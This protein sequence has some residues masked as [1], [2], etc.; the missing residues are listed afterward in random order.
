MATI[1]LRRALRAPYGARDVRAGSGSRRA[2]TVTPWLAVL[3]ALVCVVA[4]VI[5]ASGSPS[6]VAFGR[7]LLEF[8]VVAT[9]IA[10]GIYALRSPVDARFGAA[11]L[12]IGFLWS[13]TALTQTSLSVPYTIGRISTWLVL[14]CV[15]YLLLAF[16]DGRIAKGLDRVVLVGF[17]GVLTFLFVGTA[18]LVE[19]FPQKTLWSSCTTACPANAVF[20]LD[21]QPA[22]LADLITIREWLVV[23]LWTG[24][25]ASMYRRWR[26]GSPFQQRAMAPV[27][28]AGAVWGLS[29]IGHILYRQLGGATDTVIAVSSVW[30]AGI[31]AV[32]ATFVIGLIRRRMLLAA[33]LAKLGAMLRAG[34]SPQRVRDAL[35]TAIGDPSIELLF[36][37]P[38]SGTWRDASGH[39]VAWP[40]PPPPGRAVTAIGTD[41][42][43]DAAVLIHDVALRND[44]E[45]LDGV[46][47]LVLAAWRHERVMADL[48]HA[49]GDVEDSRRRIAE[50]ADHERA[51]L[52]R[53]LHDGA[54]QRLIA[55]R[56]RLGLA[57]E[58]LQT[59]PAA[60]IR[61]V[62]E[63][64]FHADLAL[65]E[66]RSLAHGVY[67]SL[68]N[69]RGLPDA[70][71]SLAR[72]APMPVHIT[73]GGVTR[74]APEID[75]AV[76]FTCAEAVQNAMK[77]A[78]TATAVWI[79][80]SQ[81]GD[82][83]RFEIRDDGAGFTPADS[84]GRGL[85][86]M[87][88]RIEAIGGDVTVD[89]RPG[90]GT[91][92]CGSV[93]LRPQPAA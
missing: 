2:A 64:G 29:H 30:T 47:D 44:K 86:N 3:G 35:A 51:R 13:L 57:E 11:L 77:H 90:R 9:P 37:D 19:A 31:V 80:L 39:L 85:R 4:V 54:Q 41:G 60:G 42:G 70:L 40:R 48:A 72:Q 1:D 32:C 23:L 14:P 53:D 17:V 84:A 25:F 66:L 73:A 71:Q 87:R 8:L 28:I 43:S 45:L 21:E 49:M 69:D 34:A 15:V 82:V 62:H 46:S 16:P 74:H 63:L 24:L 20:V 10:G 52:E 79:D 78:D 12:A 55:L 81:S 83:L 89:S 5:S 56:I 93:E 76:Y 36:R 58:L 65:E 61:A 59:D 88:D 75:S 27:F 67:P 18:P 33:T 7:G 91:R 38:Q 68:L 26:A 22:W 92:V 6:D 50:A